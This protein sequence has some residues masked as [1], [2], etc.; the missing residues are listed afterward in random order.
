MYAEP[1]W[2]WRDCDQCQQWILD[3]SNEPERDRHGEP[4]PN[5]APVECAATPCSEYTP[6]PVREGKPRFSAPDWAAY[7]RWLLC[8]MLSVTPLPGSLAEQN[9]W[10]LERFLIL[11]SH[12]RSA[13]HQREAATHAQMLGAMF[14]GKA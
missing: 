1:T 11:E 2:F 3:K 4:V 14:G 10:D 5:S 9:P 6:K 8:R 7:K 12:E 13:E